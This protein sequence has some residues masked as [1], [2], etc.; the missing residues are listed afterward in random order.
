MDGFQT[1][2]RRLIIYINLFHT[3]RWSSDK[4]A[5]TNY[6]INLHNIYKWTLDKIAH[7]NK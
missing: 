5:S 3:N 1:K 2:V 6:Y 4:I 7:T